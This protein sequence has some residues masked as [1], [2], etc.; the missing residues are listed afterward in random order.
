MQILRALA[1]TAVFA[2]VLMAQSNGSINGTIKDSKGGVVA[3]AR[4]TVSNPD[5]A[6]HTTATSNAEGAFVF[7]LLPPGTYT[8]TAEMQGFKKAEKSGVIVPVATKVSTGDIVLDVGSLTETVTVEAEAGQL[9]IQG[10]S[11]ERSNVVTNRQL[12][13]IALNGRNVIDLMRTIPGVIAG[14]VTANA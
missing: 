7:P 1:A 6:V 11:G 12:R 13:N 4:V 14:G 8:V 2:G 5:Q 3:G 10:D 9:Q